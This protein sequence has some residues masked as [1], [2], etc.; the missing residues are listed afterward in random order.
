[1]RIFISLKSKIVF[2]I[3]SIMIITTII[4]IY[5]TN[6]DISKAMLDQQN[7]LSKNVL[8]LIDL[9]IQGGYN[10]LISNKLNSILRYK[11]ILKSRT[12]NTVK[13]IE[14][15]IQ[16]VKKKELSS[17]NAKD[18]IKRWV[19]NS[20]FNKM[21]KLFIADTDLKII[22][23]PNTS[24]LGSD[25]SNFVDMKNKSI[26]ENISSSMPETYP[27]INVY[28]WKSA[29]DKTS[30]YLTC[31]RKYKEWNWIIG[32]I[33][34]IDNIEIEADQEQKKI[35]EILKDTFSEI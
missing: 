6:K 20:D 15:Q 34:N 31:L 18:I 21:G 13:M 26:L 9:N 17:K 3:T 1:M 27:V 28:N 16:Y 25:I 12:D 4:I 23:Y 33:I 22:A 5:F 11:N 30:K 19:N 8:Y 2:L 24:Y 7:M 35:V 32:S 10:N 29:D 14:Q